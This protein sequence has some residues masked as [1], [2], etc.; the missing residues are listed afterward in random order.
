MTSKETPDHL[1]PSFLAEWGWDMRIGGWRRK[2][3]GGS[4]SYRVSVHDR[5]SGGFR[6]TLYPLGAHTVSLVMTDKPDGDIG[7]W[8]KNYD[9]YC[10][11]LGGTDIWTSTREEVLERAEHLGVDAE[12]AADALSVRPRGRP[13]LRSPRPKRI[14]MN[15]D[16]AMLEALDAKSVELFGV[17]KKNRPRVVSKLLASL[18]EGW[19]PPE[20]V[21]DVTSDAE[22]Q[23][24]IILMSNEDL[25]KLSRIQAVRNLPSRTAALRIMIEHDLDL[26]KPDPDVR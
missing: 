11:R 14:Y 1:H 10:I 17:A 18:P 26:V 12:L 21:T 23:P 19:E 5:D 2:G 20:G 9:R 24:T 8:A 16:P 15:L 13:Q 25:N 6:H 22:N 7:F 3:T 4:R